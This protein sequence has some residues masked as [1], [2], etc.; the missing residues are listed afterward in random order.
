MAAVRRKDITMM[1][2]L[3]AHGASL[4][5]AMHGN[6]GCKSHEEP[7]CLRKTALLVALHT[8]N[9]Q[10]IREL[11]TSGAD[12][13]QS[14]GPVGTV[15]HCFYHQGLVV[16]LLIQLGIDL[17]AANEDG[18]TAVSLILLRYHDYGSSKNFRALKLLR[19]LL[20][21]TRDLDA[22]LHGDLFAKGLNATL[23][24]DYVTIFLQHGA[25]MRYTWMY[26]TVSHIWR[27]F[28]RQ[29]GERH[30]ERFIELLRVADT[31]FSDVRQRIA[32]VDKDQSK[33]LN[34]AVL[35]QKLS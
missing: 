24:S 9:T 34:L 31:D 25:R 13:N 1:R 18:N 10:V 7:K 19:T 32:S 16:Q 26:L 3:I 8:K 30:S 2:L 20:P 29:Y 28:L 33:W 6:F 5:E 35:D 27:S 12:V 17:D 23:D 21:M 4:S 14:L 15:L 22:V 11:V